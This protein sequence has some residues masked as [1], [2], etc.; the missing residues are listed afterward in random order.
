MDKLP[1]FDH[2]QWNEFISS[3]DQDEYCRNWI[4]I[5]CSLIPSAIQGV[6]FLS[7]PGTGVFGPVSKWPESGK[8]PERLD[9]LQL[10]FEPTVRKCSLTPWASCNGEQDGLNL[11]SGAGRPWREIGF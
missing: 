7:N 8:N 2:N 11:C 6:L 3:R 5:Q 4:G 9:L 10:S 1:A